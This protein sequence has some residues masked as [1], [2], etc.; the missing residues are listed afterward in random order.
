LCHSEEAS[1]GDGLLE[2]LM[3]TNRDALIDAAA[4]SMRCQPVSKARAGPRKLR[5]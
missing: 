1:V 5:S 2:A 4:N 3:I